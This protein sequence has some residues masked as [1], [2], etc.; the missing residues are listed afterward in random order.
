MTRT[1]RPGRLVPDRALVAAVLADPQTKQELAAVKEFNGRA[2]RS[3]SSIAGGRRF[4]AG[5]A[6]DRLPPAGARSGPGDTIPTGGERGPTRNPEA[7]ARLKAA[8]PLVEGRAQELRDA[9]R[10]SAHP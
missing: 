2:S 4:E 5:R 9:H 3:Q 6:L 8:R 1:C 7:D 10:E